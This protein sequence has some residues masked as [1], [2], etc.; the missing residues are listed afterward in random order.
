MK[1]DKGSNPREPGGGIV[2]DPLGCCFS[3]N[4]FKE[5]KKL[6]RW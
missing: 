2:V 6:S 5:S 3:V 4:P 1:K